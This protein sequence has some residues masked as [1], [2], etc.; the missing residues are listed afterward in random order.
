VHVV[1]ITGSPMP[2]R[3]GSENAN[4]TGDERNAEKRLINKERLEEGKG[5]A[6]PEGT[7]Q[8]SP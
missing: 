8:S 6:E 5:R 7:A 2:N 1:G 4:V 3:S